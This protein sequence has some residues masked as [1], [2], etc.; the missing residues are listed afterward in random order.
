MSGTR[1]RFR[2]RWWA[3]LVTLVF[4]ALTIHLGHWQGARAQYKIDQQR[5]LDS[6]LA[7]PPM[8]VWDVPRA[9]LDPS[10]KAMTSGSNGVSDPS[11]DNAPG[12]AFRY[13]SVSLVGE[14]QPNALYFLDNKIQDGKAGYGVLQLFRAYRDRETADTAGTKWLL[15]DR[16]WVAADADRSKLPALETPRGRVEIKGRV[17]L[18]V[19][20][21]PGTADNQS[22]TARLNYVNLAELASRSTQPLEAFLIE[23]TDGAGFLNTP[24]AA[25]AANYQKNLAY[26]VQWY[27]FAALAAILFLLLSFKKEP[28]A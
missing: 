16:G 19:S 27:A 21:N 12:I 11:S 25:P 10:S 1:R 20:R 18:P 22:G 23:Q 9:S 15:V 8:S 26:Q 24:R 7:A 13:R 17:N 5:Q 28:T 3:A 4:A 6:A 2:P 14:F